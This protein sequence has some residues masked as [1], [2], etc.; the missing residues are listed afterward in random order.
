M[1]D[2]WT[3][4]HK[5]FVR[6]DEDRDGAAC[7]GGRNAQATRA[8]IADP[9]AGPLTKE[10]QHS[11]CHGHPGSR[12]D[13]ISKMVQPHKLC[14]VD[15]AA[16]ETLPSHPNCRIEELLPQRWKNLVVRSRADSSVAATMAA[17]KGGR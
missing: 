14:G 5:N 1:W 9:D 11:R 2:G 13:L 3:L 15:G 6:K 10:P 4:T 16:P 7:G 12:A 17:R 8:S